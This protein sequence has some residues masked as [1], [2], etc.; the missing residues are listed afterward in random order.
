MSQGIIT[1]IVI[2]RNI[3]TALQQRCDDLELSPSD[4]FEHLF[5][6]ELARL[7]DDQVP[8]PSKRSDTSSWPQRTDTSFGPTAAWQSARHTTD[9]SLRNAS[10]RTGKTH[11]M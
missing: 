1:T 11:S 9:T 6:C 3:W 8:Q 4:Y 7:A 2:D 10:V 5:R